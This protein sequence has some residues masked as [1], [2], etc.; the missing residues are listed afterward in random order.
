M[1]IS[2]LQS[3]SAQ[4]NPFFSIILYILAIFGAGMLVY[5]GGGFFKTLL[6]LDAKAGLTV[7]VLNGTA[8]VYLDN[9]KLGT[10]PFQSATIKPGEHTVKIQ[11]GSR[12]YQTDIK[13]IADGSTTPFVDIKRDLGIS[14]IFSSG[15]TAW[16]E[17]NDSGTVLSLISE[18]NGAAV[19]IDGTEIGRTPF[20]SNTLT[21]GEYDLRIEYPSYEAQTSRV[22]IQKSYNL[23]ISAKLFPTPVLAKNSLFEGSTN[24]YNV[25]LDNN[26]VTSN[27]EN[28]VKAIIYWNTT[29]GINLAGQGT[30]KTP[31]FD[32]YLDYKGVVY[33]KDG[34]AIANP[35]GYDVIKSAKQ[36]VYLGRI[37]D[38]PGLTAAAKDTYKILNIGSAI[39]TSSSS[40]GKKATIKTT[41]TGWLR[42]RSLPSLS[43]VELAKVNT[44]QVFDVLEEKTGWIKIKVSET[45]TGWVSADYVEVK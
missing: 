11:N 6:K 12:V 35:S 26:L 18:P 21:S 19:F 15:Q 25:A 13:F 27:P 39:T 37:S 34:T 5:F 1:T 31:V 8:D 17:K 10:T 9:T 41:T 4:Q 44:G 29:R 24:L 22:V 30:S 38:G 42:V 33:T 14:D 16:Y 45:V 2:T 23:N 7:E 32:F 43:G 3:K 36:G 40:V 28:W 20:S